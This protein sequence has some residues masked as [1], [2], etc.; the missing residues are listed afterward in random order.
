[1]GCQ[2]FEL[3]YGIML[4]LHVAGDLDFFLNHV[5][6]LFMELTSFTV[7]TLSSDMNCVHSFALQSHVCTVV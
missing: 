6:S 4:L 5:L 3:C 2:F 7:F 1:M